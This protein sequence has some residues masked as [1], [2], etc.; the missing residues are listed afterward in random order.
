MACVGEFR[1]GVV[2]C[3]SKTSSGPLHMLTMVKYLGRAN[4]LHVRNWKE[5]FSCGCLASKRNRAQ[6]EESRKE[7][8]EREG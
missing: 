6:G 7:E 3:I 1:K 4:G 8:A 2:S 5:S